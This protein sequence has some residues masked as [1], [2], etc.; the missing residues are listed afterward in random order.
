MSEFASIEPA[1]VVA[2]ACRQR[3]PD[4]TREA[5]TVI[6]V[7]D[8][9]ATRERQAGPYGVAE[10]GAADKAANLARWKS[11]CRQLPVFGRLAYPVRAEATKHDRPGRKIPGCPAA[12]SAA[13]GTIWGGSKLGGRNI[14]EYLHPRNH[15]P[16]RSR[17]SWDKTREADP[18]IAW[19]MPMTSGKKQGRAHGVPPGYGIQHPRKDSQR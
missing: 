7:Q 6:A 2:T 16:A 5:L 14:K 11:L 18:V 10:R 3:G 19:G 13:V 1:G 17:N 8:Q 4:A 12:V 9:L 15:G